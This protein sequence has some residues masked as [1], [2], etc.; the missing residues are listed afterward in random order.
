MSRLA[1]K[2]TL[3]TGAGR[4]IGKAIALTYAR[5]GACVICTARTAHEV[6][7]VADTIVRQGG[8]GRAVVADGTRA[9]DVRRLLDRGLAGRERHDI[10]V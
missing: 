4:G 2:V 6:N 10:L 5:E 8:E 1:G 7:G 9:G 3:V